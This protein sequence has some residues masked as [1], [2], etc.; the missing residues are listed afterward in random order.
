M[1]TSV[2]H[3]AL[4]ITAIVFSSLLWGTIPLILRSID[5]SPFIKVF[6]R[7]FVSFLVLAIW[8]LVSG[9]WR[10]ISELDSFSL[11]WV[12]AQGALL[13]INWILFFGAFDHADIATV[14]L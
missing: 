11:R 12:L 4:G 3:R 1:Q 14:E 8:L 7:V 5:G 9:R 2:S 13:G 10:K 6:F